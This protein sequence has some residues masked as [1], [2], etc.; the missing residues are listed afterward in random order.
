[1]NKCLKNYLFA[2]MSLVL[3]LLPLVAQSNAVPSTTSDLSA[4][5][6][7][8]ELLVEQPR[9][10]TALAALLA[11]AKGTNS[12]DRLRS[13][14]MAGYALSTLF[15]GNTNLY[16]SARNSH[17][18]TY[19]DDAHLLRIDLQACYERCEECQG[20]GK[21]T[22]LCPACK[23]SD[24]CKACNGEGERLRRK[25]L[26]GSREAGVKCSVCKGTGRVVCEM[27]RGTGQIERPCSNCKGKPERFVTPTKVYNDFTLIVKGITK[28]INNEVVFSE[29]LKIAKSK[30]DL[31]E[32]V[33]AL[34]AL[35]AKSSYREDI[36]D[37]ETL[38]ATE[39]AAL[40]E[41]TKIMRELQEREQREI[42]LLRGLRSSPN[43]AA[44]IVTLNEYLEGHPDSEHR[45][46]LQ[47]IVNHMTAELHKQRIKRRNLYV[48]G[49]IIILL[50]AASCIHINHYNYNIFSPHKEG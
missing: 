46:E 1:M 40:Q 17:S 3:L 41:Q 42:S 18:R 34:Q 9:D 12:V 11:Y 8:C 10:E 32:R 44:S 49:G 33:A 45:L 28:W 5:K 27:C 50:L 16:I 30:A 47:S 48:F 24:K 7:T 19:P 22:N 23:G 39:Q 35:V 31:T 6:K 26:K 43:F 2:S 21:V 38:L 36:G 25:N 20:R 13:R 4:L 37:V 14:A 15:K 29:N